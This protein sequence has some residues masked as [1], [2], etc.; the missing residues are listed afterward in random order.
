MKI[1]RNGCIVAVVNP[2][3]ASRWRRQRDEEE[4]EEE[5]EEEKTEATRWDGSEIKD[6]CSLR[7]SGSFLLPCCSMDEGF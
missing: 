5:G 2:A 7:N 4:E 3:L 1:E 6:L